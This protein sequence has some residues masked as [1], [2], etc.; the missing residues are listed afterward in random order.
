[1]EKVLVLESCWVS[2]SVDDGDVDNVTVLDGVRRGVI[3][4]EGWFDRLLLILPAGEIDVDFDET[5][6]KDGVAVKV[7]VS[8]GLALSVVLSVGVAVLVT[9]RLGVSIRVAVTES[10]EDNEFVLDCPPLMLRVSLRS[11]DGVRV[12]D[13]SSEI[14]TDGVSVTDADTDALLVTVAE[15]VATTVSVLE[16]ETEV[17]FVTEPCCDRDRVALNSFEKESVTEGDALKDLVSLMTSL[18]VMDSELVV[19]A[20]RDGV[21]ESLAVTEGVAD[22]LMDRC[23]EGLRVRD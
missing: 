8:D 3:V 10:D 5:A 12:V 16:S 1:M 15:A 20:D 19:V 6:E 23:C 18:G 13:G 9:V 21:R 7:T 17:V 2:V 22:L 4:C 11:F 14:E